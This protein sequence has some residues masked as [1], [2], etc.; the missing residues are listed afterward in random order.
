MQVSDSAHTG[1]TTDARNRIFG[2]WTSFCVEHHVEPSLANVHDAE[3]RLCY[4]LVFSMRY[5]SEG[6]KG[7]SVSAN[8]VTDA[9][10]AVGA[11]I[12]NLGQP[13]PRK[14]TPGSN[15]NHPLLAAFLK[16]LRDKDDPAKRSY[17]ANIP[18]VRNLWTILGVNDPIYGRVNRHVCDLTIIAFYWLLRPAEYTPSHGA[19]RSQ[20]FRFCDVSFTIGD[21]FRSATDPSLNDVHESSVT[22][23]TLTFT[24]Q[25]NGV[26]GEQV[27]QRANSDP[28][29]CPAKALF[30]AHPTPPGLPR[31]GYD[32]TLHLLRHNRQ[33]PRRHQHYNHQR[34]TSQCPKSPTDYR[35]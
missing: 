32:S 4:L 3:Q 9:L 28:I 24:D 31:P 22:S 14:E 23:A 25:K 20:A 18:I 12:A 7:K 1:K 8:T 29:M 13:D 2:I 17:P 27:A 11:G 16:G 34:S 6:Q 5:R 35:H 30:S 19:G 26:R 33:S 15:R 21:A 10:L